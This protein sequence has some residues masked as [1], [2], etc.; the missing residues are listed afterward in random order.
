MA[1][2]RRSALPSGRALLILGS[3]LMI[4]G[5]LQSWIPGD[6]GSGGGR[7][8]DTTIGVIVSI[9]AVGILG[10][11]VI[12][13]RYSRWI[14][15]ILSGSAGGWLLFWSMAHSVVH[16]PGWWLTLVGVSLCGLVA[17]T[18]TVWWH[19]A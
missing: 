17:L 10:V 6:P 12:Q 2:H 11:A 3:L 14:S 4:L 7:G 19:E 9:L 18:P 16:A 13:P 15:F 1:T 8:V 5:G